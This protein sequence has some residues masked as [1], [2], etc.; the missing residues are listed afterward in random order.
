HKLFAPPIYPGAIRREGILHRIFTNSSVRV[1]LLQGPAGHGKSTTLQQIKSDYESK[2]SLTAWLTLDDADNDPRRFA[3]HIRALIDSLCHQ[4]YSGD[5]IGHVGARHARRSD[6]VLDSLSR[7]QKPVAL[8]FDEFQTIR[9]RVPLGFFRDFFDRVPENVRI[10][11]G[12]RSLPEVGLAKLLVNNVA[13]VL[14]ADD[15]RFSP[16]EVDRFFASADD[17][18]ISAEEIG[19]IYRR[20]EGW[21]AALQLYRLTLVSPEVR[22]SLDDIGTYSPRELAEYLADNVLTLQSPRVQEFLLRTS[23]LTRLNAD[24]CDAVMGW[25]DSQDVLM[26]LERSGLFIRSLDVDARWFKYHGLF[27]AIMADNLRKLSAEAVLEVHARAAQWHLRQSLHEE[28]VHHALGCRDF[29]LAANTLNTWASRLVASGQL[30]TVER[31]SDC[32]PFDRIVERPD[33]AIKIAYSLAFLRRERKLRPL[34]DVLRR[35]IDAGDIA[36]TTNSRVALSMA[37][38]LEDDIPGA[39]ALVEPLRLHEH[40]I[41]GFATFEIGAGSN[42]LAY[43]DIATGDFEGARK[44]LALARTASDRGGAT[45]SGG[46]AL[47]LSGACLIYQ[48]QL[49]DAIERFRKE[50][51]SGSAHIDGSFASAALASCYIWALYEANELDAVE[52]VF[53][54]Y[55]DGI[56][57][58]V[59]P[60]FIALAH[61]SMSRTFDAR[62]RPDKALEVLDEFEKIGHD[63]GWTRL[64][65]MADWERV[66]RALIA[67]DG[68]RA[69][70]IAAHIAPLDQLYAEQ[71][72]S[73][74][75]DLEGEALGR[76][77]LAV[78]SLDAAV[79]NARIAREL[80]R[81]PNRT[82]RQ[83]KLHLMGAQLKQSEGMHNAAHRSLRKAV[84]LA[85]PGRYIRCFL[86][87]GE[88][89]IELLREAY[90]N[91]F[92]GTS[93]E[94]VDLDMNQ[95]FIEELLAASGTDLTRSPA[96]ANRSSVQ[97]L[98]DREKEMLNLLANGVSNKEMAQKLFVSENTVKFHLKNVY[99]KMG[100]SNR[101]QAI[102]TARQLGFIV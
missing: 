62:G 43:R 37:A 102:N 78:H 42:L 40:A 8:F 88:G 31:W 17:L 92:G 29:T 34:L 79:A 87:E 67:G 101:L 85:K 99:S 66:R 15:L 60:D 26:H 82:Y 64:I 14:R 28:V 97:P 21:P 13:L 48:G 63:S 46:Y 77:R 80:E 36:H 44:G 6:W 41:D 16:A 98:S 65:G 11:V 30:M 53:A 10:F 27:S 18:K 81:Q 51:S 57:E 90:Q 39:V 58:S 19:A 1:I 86:D 47:A 75:E 50:M 22:N 94:D 91:I 20:T 54:R 9:N 76:I 24:L 3:I 2:E 56:A 69:R 100:V 72:I 25:S 93:R 61:I 89:V 73:M 95:I 52:A 68:D 70:A 38:V 5:R 71:W 45:F 23:L 32:I 84:Q 12:S 35:N 96:K 59:I 7:L 83:I 49:R 55:H 33:L 4:E 74:S